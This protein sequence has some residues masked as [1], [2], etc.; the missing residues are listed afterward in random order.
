M[1]TGPYRRLMRVVGPWDGVSNRL[2]GG[3]PHRTNT[4]TWNQAQQ[5]AVQGTVVFSATNLTSYV[6]STAALDAFT[7]N[8]R[9]NNGQVRQCPHAPAVCG[10]DRWCAMGGRVPQLSFFIR[11]WCNTTSISYSNAGFDDNQFQASNFQYAPTYIPRH[12]PEEKQV[13]QW[14]AQADSGLTHPSGGAVY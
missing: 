12:C 7:A 9:A 14:A 10:T 13:G 3:G 6:P 4:L 1:A 11:R 2:D 8:L 5:L